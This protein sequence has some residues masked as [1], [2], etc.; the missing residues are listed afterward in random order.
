MAALDRTALS[1]EL[2]LLLGLSG[3]VPPQVARSV[4]AAIEYAQTV[5]GVTE[6]QADAITNNGTIGFAR[7]LY[8]DMR[9]ARGQQVN[10][11]DGVADN[12][13]QPEDIWRHWRHYF[14]PQREAWGIA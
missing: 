6:L 13:F 14:E 9:A 12:I 4:D 11:G 8:L 2:A 3:D 7:S 5:L 1:A 10:V